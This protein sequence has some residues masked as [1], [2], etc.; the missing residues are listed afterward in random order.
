MLFGGFYNP[1][2]HSNRLVSNETKSKYSKRNLSIGDIKGNMAQLV[3]H[4][5]FYFFCYER[6]WQL[7]LGKS[8]LK[9][10]FDE[11]LFVQ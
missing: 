5:C 7:G 11:L 4:V 1:A 3:K 9:I 10:S 8:L 2:V 6:V